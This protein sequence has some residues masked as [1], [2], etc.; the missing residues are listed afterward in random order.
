MTDDEVAKYSL[1]YCSL[2]K[3]RE[4]LYREE[5]NMARLSKSAF[6]ILFVLSNEKEVYSQSKLCEQLNLTRQTIN[7]T[8][9]NLEKQGIINL[10]AVPDNRKEKLIVLTEKGK[11]LMKDTI[12]DFVKAENSVFFQMGDEEVEEFLKLMKRYNDLFRA[13]LMKIS[14][15]YSKG[16]ATHI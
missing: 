8:V 13:E 16:N 5:A 7:S 15:G 6:S 12:M 10:K 4:D 3:E 1:Q 2:S 9:L 14:S 11:Q